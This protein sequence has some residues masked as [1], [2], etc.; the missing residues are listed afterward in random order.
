MA[1]VGESVGAGVR[2]AMVVGLAVPS[3]TWAQAVT[4]LGGEKLTEK[5]VANVIDLGEVAP[6]V[7]VVGNTQGLSGTTI[8]IRGLGQEDPQAAA[9]AR[10]LFDRKYRTYGIDF[11]PLFGFSSNVY[12]D[13]QT[14]GLQL[15]YNFSAS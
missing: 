1:N 13:P 2:L 6:N 3:A 15:T 4:A 8:T 7:R 11:G 9:F 5:G 12:G 10:N 14:F